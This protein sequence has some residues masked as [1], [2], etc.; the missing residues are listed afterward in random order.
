VDASKPIPCDS[1]RRA[2][3]NESFPDSGGHL[4]SA[5]SAFF[6]LLTTMARWMLRNLHYSILL[7][8]RIPTYPV[9]MLSDRWLKGYSY[10]CTLV[11]WVSTGKFWATGCYRHADASKPI[12]F[13]SPR[14]ADY[15]ETLPDSGGHLPPEVT[16]FFF[17]LTSIAIRTLRNLHHSI[18][19][20]LRI[21][22]HP[23]QTLTDHWLQGYPFFCTFVLRASTFKMLATGC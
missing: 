17:L 4:P 19:L 7:D 16:L 18:P 22:M 12:P 1:P 10:M 9:P 6:F 5:I 3:Y 13:N 8:R 11:L 15:K 2:D 23:V 21:P 20:N 14:R